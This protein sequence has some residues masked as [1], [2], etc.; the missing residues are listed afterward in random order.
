MVVAIR[1]ILQYITLVLL[2][3][4][5]GGCGLSTDCLGSAGETISEEVTIAPF[6]SIE[7]HEDIELIVARGDVHKV[8]VSAGKNII[9]NVGVDVV[10]GR[11]FLTTDE[12]CGWQSGNKVTSIYVTTPELTEIRSYTQFA[13]R[14]QG[15]LDFERL[16]LKSV[17]LQEPEG[18]ATGEF[19]LHIDVDRLSIEANEFANFEIKGRAD[20]L[21]LSLVDGTV[22]A[23][24]PDLEVLDAQVYH[25]SAQH[26]TIRPLLSVKGSLWGTG[27]LILL[28][29]PE[30]IEVEENY[31][32]KVIY[33]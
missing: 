2:F 33:D 1:A 31:T 22:R 24:M 5:L 27:D 32:G 12:P 19:F 23:Y 21:W 17:V 15:V 3:S 16:T 29:T 25:R 7:V 9:D 6:S 20:A 13:V 26:I 4:V 28:N 11:L 14:S 30:V 8:V 18:V 10:E